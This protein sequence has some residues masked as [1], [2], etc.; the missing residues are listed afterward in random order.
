MHGDRGE[1]MFCIEATPRRQLGED[2]SWLKT[3]GL[4]SSVDATGSVL[5]CLEGVQRLARAVSLGGHARLFW[6]ITGTPVML[7]YDG[8]G[9]RAVKM[10]EEDVAHQMETDYDAIYARPSFVSIARYVLADL[11]AAFGLHAG[12]WLTDSGSLEKA[13][14]PGS[15]RAYIE[16]WGR[17]GGYEII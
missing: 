4:F 10:L 11:F 9:G 1:S 16:K 15:S 2:T 7:L 14:M 5:V 17:R 13:K 6:G 12:D 8:N 3:N